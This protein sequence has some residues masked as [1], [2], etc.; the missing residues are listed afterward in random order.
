[1]RNNNDEKF[2]TEIRDK[3]ITF[4]GTILRELKLDEL[5]QLW[6]IVKGDMRFIGP[7]PEVQ[8]FISS[9]DFSFLTRIKPGLTDFSSIL[10][11]NE[12]EIL[13]NSGGIEKY[14]ML[15]EVKVRLANLYVEHKS[16]WLDMKLVILTLVSIFFPKTAITLVKKLFIEKYKPDLIPAIND[17]IK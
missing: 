1:M 10:L 8:E 9:N 17:W 14:P 16:F 4:W 6:N 2:I 15:L 12:S 5:P 11:R 3:R 13:S 7:R